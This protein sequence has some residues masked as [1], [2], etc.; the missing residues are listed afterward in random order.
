MLTLC[1]LGTAVFLELSLRI[2]SLS[3]LFPRQRV[4]AAQLPNRVGNAEETF[5]PQ[6]EWP[7]YASGSVCC[8]TGIESFTSEHTSI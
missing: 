4:Y 3:F 8:E 6:V 2:Q 1:H 7:S 5:A